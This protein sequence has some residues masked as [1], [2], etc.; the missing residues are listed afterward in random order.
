VDVER[1][2]TVALNVSEINKNTRRDFNETLKCHCNKVLLHSEILKSRN[3][4]SQKD[5]YLKLT[6]HIRT[7]DPVQLTYSPDIVRQYMQPIVTVV[8]V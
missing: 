5:E 4:S 8:R 1:S 7:S 6:L 2:N 3:V